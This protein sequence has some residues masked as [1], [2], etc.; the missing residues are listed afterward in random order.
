MAERTRRTSGGQRP[1]TWRDLVRSRRARPGDPTLRAVGSDSGFTLVEV[2]MT[3]VLISMTIVPLID[4]TFTSIKA[5]STIREVAEIETVLQNAADRV[6]RAPTLCDYTIYVQAAAQA[7]GWTA[8]RASATHKYYV[9]G[10]SALAATPGSWVNGACPNNVR[11]PRL[12]QM[13]TVT[14]TSASGSISRKIEV[15]KSDI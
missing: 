6:N 9:P 1:R 4:A 3:I 12:I 14:V 10:T 15:V 8:N 7:N 13:V 2:V 5:S 11:T